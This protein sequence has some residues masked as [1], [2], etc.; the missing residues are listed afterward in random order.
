MRRG[1]PALQAYARG[2]DEPARAK[3]RM[4]PADRSSAGGE[5]VPSEKFGAHRAPP[6]SVPLA[7][8]PRRRRLPGV[9]APASGAESRLNWTWEASLSELH[10]G[11]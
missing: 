3:H 9:L 7:E 5:M 1:L 2:A 10:R 11:G 6:A 8:S 4:K